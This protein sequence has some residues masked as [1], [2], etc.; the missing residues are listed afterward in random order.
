MGWVSPGPY[1][2]VWFWMS[3]KLDD[4]AALHFFLGLNW[5]T[6]CELAQLFV[7]ANL[8]VRPVFKFFWINCSN[9]E[10]LIS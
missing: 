5:I 1:D 7:R 9:D 2:L 4:G 8:F 6:G 3:M 10:I